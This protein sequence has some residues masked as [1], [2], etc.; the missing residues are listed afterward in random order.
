MATIDVGANGRIAFLPM[1]SVF[2]S[3]LA[4]MGVSMRTRAALHLEMLALR[5]QLDVL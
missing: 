4:T 2:T 5:H 3:L 1:L